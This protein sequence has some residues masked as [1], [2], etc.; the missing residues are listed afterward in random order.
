MM[1][2]W[3]V[4]AWNNSP[5]YAY[6]TEEQVS[7]WCD[8]LDGDRTHNLHGYQPIEPVPHDWINYHGG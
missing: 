8:A 3:I 2:F 7:E 5:Y 6:A 1:Q 4:R